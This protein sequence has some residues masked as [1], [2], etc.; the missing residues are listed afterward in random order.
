[1]KITTEP[2]YNICDVNNYC[3]VVISTDK[4]L[5]DKT[6]PYKIIGG[7]T[8]STDLAEKNLALML[9]TENNITIINIVLGAEDNF[10]DT[11]S[12]INNLKINK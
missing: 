9:K 5:T 8:G 7:K 3:K 4:F 2:E 6:F 12:L 1:M 10:A 11:M